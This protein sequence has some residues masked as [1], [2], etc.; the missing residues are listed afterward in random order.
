MEGSYIRKGFTLIETIISVSILIYISP[1]FL[2]IID[3]MINYNHQITE[4]QNFIGIIQLRRSLSLGVNHSINQNEICMIYNDENM[5]F[6]QFESNLIANPGTQY[7]LVKVHD[8]SFEMIGNW[9]VI[10]YLSE[11]KEYSIKLI[12]I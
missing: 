9:L 3:N 6:E 1:L 10:N 7:F 11:S 4:R 12:Q 2:I 5:C 8:V